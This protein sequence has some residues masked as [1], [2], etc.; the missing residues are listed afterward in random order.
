MLSLRPPC[1]MM[2][3]FAFHH[4]DLACVISRNPATK[5]TFGEYPV[6]V[7]LR[8]FSWIFYPPYELVV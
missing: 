8:M 2:P 1:R 3:V 7:R 5:N 6:K 4:I